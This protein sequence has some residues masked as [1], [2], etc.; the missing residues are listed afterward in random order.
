PAF[1]DY[2]EGSDFVGGSLNT[3]IVED[4]GLPWVLANRNLR[5]QKTIACAVG[6][7]RN[8]WDVFILDLT[9]YYKDIR[10]TIRMITVQTA[11]G[12]TYFPNGNG[13]YA[14]QRGVEVSLRKVPSTYRWG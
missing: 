7:E 2:G 13:D 4:T 1:N 3:F 11:D 5:P 12:G 6:S 8:F 9:G 14:D 10:N